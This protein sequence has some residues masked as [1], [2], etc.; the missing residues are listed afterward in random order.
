VFAISMAWFERKLAFHLVYIVHFFFFA[1]SCSLNYYCF[2]HY[3][4]LYLDDY[5]YHCT[6][7]SR[8]EM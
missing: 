4:S 5:A 6:R 3:T 8:D 1:F 7:M 2:T